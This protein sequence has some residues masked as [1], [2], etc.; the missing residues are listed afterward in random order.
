MSTIVTRAG[1]GTPLT[2]NEVDANFV[3]LNTDK[4]QSGDTVS[5]LTVSNI[6]VTGGSING[7][8]IGASTAGTGGFSNL[9]YT[10]TLTGSTG[11]LNIGNG[12][13][14]K[15][16]N[17]NVGIGTNSLIDFGVDYK[18][19][20]VAGGIDGSYYV[21]SSRTVRLDVG[22][23][24]AGSGEGYV[25]T[26][27]NHSLG[28]FTNGTRRLSITEAGDIIS[29][30]LYENVSSGGRDVQIASNGTLYAVSS[31][32]KYK[33]NV[34]DLDYALVD[35]AISN[36]RPVYY[37]DKEPKGDVKEGWSH[38]GLIAEE[39]AEVEPRIVHYKTTE[40]TFVD[41]NESKNKERVETKLETPVPEGID[42]ARLSIL[43]LAEL[44]KQREIIADLKSRIE[45]LE[46][47]LV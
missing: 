30:T 46:N 45:V 32:L 4:I 44:Q 19:V 40:V 31:S 36:L 5:Q 28:L 39:A 7:T 11:V 14:Y 2:Y 33:T 24:G 22:A 3:N 29:S 25:G 42:Y 9:S 21:A 1:K 35:N 17:G 47:V 26:G 43:C 10:G 20:E 41:N 8:N 16:A 27:T 13:I 34:E 12:Q 18:T 6:N 38:L 15:D 23:E 37:R